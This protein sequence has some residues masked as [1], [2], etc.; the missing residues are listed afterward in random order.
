MSLLVGTTSGLFSIGDTTEEVIGGTRINHVSR[1]ESGWWAVDGKGRIHHDG[2]V[3]AELPEDAPAI[4]I[5]PTPDTVWVGSSEA[6]L[7]ALD[8]GEVSEDEFFAEAPGREAWYTPWGGPADVRSMTLDA[9]HTLYVNVHVG[10]ILRY[11]NTGLVP[12]L[13]ID[14]DV[15]EV[16]AHPTRKGAIFAATARGLAYS[17]N[18]H[19]FDFR[20]KGLH[21]TYCRAVTVL[22]DRVVFSAST[23]P[24]SERGRL[25]RCSLWDD[26][27]E[28]VTN[29]LPEWFDG[30]V[31]THCLTSDGDTVH[32]AHGGRVWRSDDQ[33]DSWQL[34][35][36]DLARVTTLI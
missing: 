17:H 29:G 36:E 23:G 24:R 28:P 25:Y 19:D 15:H 21:A 11:D 1:D 20:S 27:I 4:C 13:D 31:D 26:D 7:F 2:D 9:D 12:T 18:G 5:Q 14:A 30:N 10:G 3:V 22:D 34:Q 16:I 8:H 6:R 32:V 33:G 35:T